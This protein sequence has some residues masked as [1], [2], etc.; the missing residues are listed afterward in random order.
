MLLPTILL[1]GLSRSR[2]GRSTVWLKRLKIIHRV[3]YFLAVNVPMLVIRLVVW[4]IHKKDVSVFLI[5]NVIGIG[6]VV[7]EVYMGMIEIRPANKPDD[8]QIKL[9]ELKPAVQSPVEHQQMLALGQV[10]A[11]SEHV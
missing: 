9:M 1:F 6:V 11:E 5:K 3:V 7:N 8:Q 10:S 4:H 2:Y